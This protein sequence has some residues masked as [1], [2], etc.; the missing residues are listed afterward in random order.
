MRNSRHGI[1]RIHAR[2]DVKNRFSQKY[3]DIPLE[4][5]Q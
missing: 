1:P 5:P 3:P 2:E 4:A